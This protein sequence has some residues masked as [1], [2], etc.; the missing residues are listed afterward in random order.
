MPYREILERLWILDQV[1]AW[2]PSRSHLR[3]LSS[4]PKHQ[5][6]DPALAGRLL[7]VD[8]DALLA[9]RAVGPVIPRDG[10]LLGAL[11]ESL[12]VLSVRVYAQAAEATVSHVRTAGG[13]HEVDI[14]VER[15]DGRVV[16][17]E[18]KLASA[19]SDRDVRGLL[20]LRDQIGADLLDAAI[21]TTGQEAYRRADGIAVIPAALLG[22]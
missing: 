13:E 12:I 20:W 19:I 14:I 15:Q 5:L 1:P 16:A 17:L 9:G 4:P 18:V 10:T 2:I 8:A 3:R 7:G 6:A 11:F 21:I 22:A